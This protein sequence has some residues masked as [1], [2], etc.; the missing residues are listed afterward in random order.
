MTGDAK[1]AVSAVDTALLARP[2]EQHAG[3]DQSLPRLG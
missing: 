3:W 2:D 1:G